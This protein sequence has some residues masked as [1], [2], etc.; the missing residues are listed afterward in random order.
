MWDVAPPERA[1]RDTA[2]MQSVVEQR[3]EGFHVP[4]TADT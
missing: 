3:D 1:A 2:P 4:T